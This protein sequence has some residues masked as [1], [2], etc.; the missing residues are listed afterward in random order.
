MTYPLP[1]KAKLKRNLWSKI[2]NIEIPDVEC[3]DTTTKKGT[4]WSCKRL[5]GC[6]QTLGQQ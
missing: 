2:E 5:G 6:E 1:Q 3:T 4:S